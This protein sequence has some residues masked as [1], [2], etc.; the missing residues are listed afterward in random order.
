MQITFTAS[1]GQSIPMLTT[2]AEVLDPSGTTARVLDNRKPNIDSN[3]S[4]PISSR[5]RLIETVPIKP[6][7]L[8]ATKHDIAPQQ[9]TPKRLLNVNKL[10]TSLSHGTTSVQ[11]REIIIPGQI[12]SLTTAGSKQQ[13]FQRESERG[14]ETSSAASITPVMRGKNLA[15]WLSKLLG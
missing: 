10:H 15:I 4:T 3:I 11:Q 6:P 9:L 8:L 12:R 5:D 13:I 1:D 14:R 7:A 2:S